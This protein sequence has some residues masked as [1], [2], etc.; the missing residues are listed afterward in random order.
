[1][2]VHAGHCF[3]PTASSANPVSPIPPETASPPP[4][5]FVVAW[6]AALEAA[7]CF[8]PPS[9]WSCGTGADFHLQM[10]STVSFSISKGS[11]SPT[12]EG[13][14][15]SSIHTLDSVKGSKVPFIPLFGH[16]R[17]ILADMSFYVSL[18]LYSIALSYMLVT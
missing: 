7:T 15:F 9:F 16:F 18:I 6:L 8:V 4:K 11:P 2:T 17:L 5:S 13:W 1:M 3:W 12:S 10:K 14:I